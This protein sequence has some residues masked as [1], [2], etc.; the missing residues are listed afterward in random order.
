MALLL[1]YYLRVYIRIPDISHSDNFTAVVPSIG[2]VA[3]ALRTA[4]RRAL[5]RWDIAGLE[6]GLCGAGLSP[7][8]ASQVMD[9][10]F[11]AAL[12]AFAEEHE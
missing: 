3:N 8:L 7:T 10:V 9:I 12:S 4:D 6:S 11:V 2:E 5:A 1:Y